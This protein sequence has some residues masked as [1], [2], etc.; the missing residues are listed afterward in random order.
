MSK[1]STITISVHHDNQ[2]SPF[3]NFTDQQNIFALHRLFEYL[4]CG[5]FAPNQMMTI[6]ELMNISRI[7]LLLGLVNVAQ[8]FKNKANFLR[9]KISNRVM[10]DF[11]I[12]HYQ[13]TNGG[14]SA[15][16]NEV[17]D[18]TMKTLMKQE[19]EKNMERLEKSMKMDMSLLGGIRS[20][21]QQGP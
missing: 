1:G 14:D 10:R 13:A 9:I 3:A 16:Q 11:Q 7:S 2:L 20:K 5:N 4:Y 19:A 6:I 12:K 21:Q 18:Q 8:D 15:G 17:H